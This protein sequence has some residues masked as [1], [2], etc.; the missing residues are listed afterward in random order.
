MW[1]SPNIKT[2][3]LISDLCDLNNIKKSINYFLIILLIFNDYWCII[4]LMYEIRLNIISEN[5]YIMV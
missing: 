2:N 4:N 1:F 3:L 5:Y